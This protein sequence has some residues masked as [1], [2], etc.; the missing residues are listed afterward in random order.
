MDC[1]WNWIFGDLETFLTFFLIFGSKVNFPMDKNRLSHNDLTRRIDPRAP[2]G[3]W[4]FSKPEVIFVIFNFPD[5][6][7]MG[8]WAQGPGPWALMETP[9]RQE[10][11]KLSYPLSQPVPGPR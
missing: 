7:P 5:L 4:I 8:P 11:S 3:P 2:E 9:E 6:G 1:G 10:P